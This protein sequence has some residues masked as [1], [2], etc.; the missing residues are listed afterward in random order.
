MAIGDGYTIVFET[1]SGDTE[2]STQTLLPLH[3]EKATWTLRRRAPHMFTVTIPPWAHHLPADFVAH[4]ELRLLRAGVYVAWGAGFMGALQLTRSGDN[5]TMELPGYGNAAALALFTRGLL[6]S[7]SVAIAADFD[8]H[9][10]DGLISAILDGNEHGSGGDWFPAAQRTLGTSALTLAR[11]S[12]RNKVALEAITDLTDL[13]G[14]SWRAGIN[15]S[16]TFTFAASGS[17]DTDR[18]ATIHAVDG[19]NCTIT[20]VA[21]DDSRLLTSVTVYCKTPAWRTLLNGAAVAGDNNIT[22][23]STAD[24]DDQDYIIIGA[25]AT[26]DARA[27][28]T[29]TSSTVLDINS[30]LGGLTYNQ[31]DNTEVKGDS[32][33]YRRDTRTAAASVA[34]S[35]H[36]HLEA[37]INDQALRQNHRQELGDALIDAYDSVQRSATVETADP[38]LIEQMLSAG[39]EPGDSI[40]LTSNHPL[41][42][43]WYA[44][45]TVKVQEMSVDL[46]PGGCRRIVLAVGDPRLDDLAVIER[47]MAGVRTSLPAGTTA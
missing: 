42:T 5:W 10:I 16:G 25:G 20:S 28:D 7:T 19:A 2:N 12:P 29:V 1:S 23:D 41:L 39:L 9:D 8:G 43:G 3:W 27:I 13:E 17:V 11:Y 30:G 18:S 35:H 37:T 6:Y 31:S 26:A 38:A 4:R 32:R 24:A 21:Q 36:A 14:W 44:A 34:Q 45:T 15:S 22:V 46:E 33:Y 40:K 47:L